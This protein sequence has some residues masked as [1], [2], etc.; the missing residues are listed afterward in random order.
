MCIITPKASR[1]KWQRVRKYHNLFSTNLSTQLRS[2]FHE[3]VYNTLSIL[4]Y[5]LYLAQPL[6]FDLLEWFDFI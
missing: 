5:F 6:T 2:H 4:P 3:R 1:V